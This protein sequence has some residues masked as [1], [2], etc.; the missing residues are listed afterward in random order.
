MRQIELSPPEK[1]TKTFDVPVTF[2]E[3]YKV[4]LHLYS[5]FLSRHYLQIGSFL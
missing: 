5:M 1:H 2:I 4:S 3:F